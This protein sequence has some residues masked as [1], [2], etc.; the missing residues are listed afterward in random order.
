M[1]STEAQR[2]Y[3]RDRR[4]RVKQEM[5][6]L[7][8]GA[9]VICGTEADLEFDHVDPATKIFQISGRGLD[10]NRAVLLAEVCKCQLLCGQHHRE[11]TK[12]DPKRATQ[13]VSR[14]GDPD[15]LP[16]GTTSGYSYHGCRCDLCREAK[17]R[18][19]R[20]GAGAPIGL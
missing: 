15:F 18:S 12:G 14:R 8:G 5:L 17:R 6:D 7:L 16:H 11:K 2:Q 10:K 1:L 3:M 9:C 4:A 19:R 13:R 20:T